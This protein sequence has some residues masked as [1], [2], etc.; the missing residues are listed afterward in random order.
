[1]R[2]VRYMGRSGEGIQINGPSQT[3]T[4]TQHD[5]SDGL[6]VC[7]SHHVDPLTKTVSNNVRPHIRCGRRAPPHR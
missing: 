1:M 5:P 3:T 7:R 4:G 2:A 6:V